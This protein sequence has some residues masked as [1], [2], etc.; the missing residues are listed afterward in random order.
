MKPEILIFTVASEHYLIYLERFLASANL[1]FPNAIIHAALINVDK[2]QVQY[3][4]SL[5]N[6]LEIEHHDIEFN[7]I[8]TLKGY[9]VNLYSRMFP[10]LLA[11]YDCPVIYMDSDSLFL[12]NADELYEYSK[13]YDLSCEINLKHPSIGLSKRKIK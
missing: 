4:R 12:K 2:L 3:L 5:Y 1:F 13:L 10:I 9:C 7:N 6:N 11:Q 8:E